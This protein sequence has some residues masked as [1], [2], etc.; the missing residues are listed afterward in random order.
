VNERPWV[1]GT[2]ADKSLR[3]AED[4]DFQDRESAH[5]FMCTVAF[6]RRAEYYTGGEG[7]ERDA[8]KDFENN[9]RRKIVSSQYR[10]R[11]VA[12]SR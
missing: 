1:V 11:G 10:S 5:V 9:G 12:K 4:Q 2:N 3:L 8:R 7:G 6:R